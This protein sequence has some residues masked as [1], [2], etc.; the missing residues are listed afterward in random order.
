MKTCIPRYSRRERGIYWK[1]VKHF[2]PG[3]RG[4]TLFGLPWLVLAFWGYEVGRKEC[5]SRWKLDMLD[6]G[7]DESDGMS[8]G[9]YF[10]EMEALIIF[11][12]LKYSFRI[13]YRES[14]FD[15]K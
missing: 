5:F 14:N 6:A 12:C 9:R 13:I 2:R 11:E 8:G 10:C 15:R 3:G 7:Y 1:R 4:G